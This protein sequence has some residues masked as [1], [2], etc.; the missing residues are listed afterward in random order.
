MSDQYDEYDGYEEYEDY[1]DYDDYD[2]DF[3]PD[4]P[5]PMMS[6]QGQPQ[7][8][9]FGQPPFGPPQGQ[10]PFGPPQGQPPFGPPQGPPGQPFLMP[11]APGPHNFGQF[12]PNMRPPNFIPRRPGFLPGPIRQCRNRF[13][14]IWLNNGRSFW[15][16]ISSVTPRV[17]YGYRWNVRRWIYFEVFVFNIIT[18]VCIR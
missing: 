16:W 18:F 14:Y 5:G 3:R 1:E 13:A 6:P 7:G 10:P 2:D 15:A 17:V 12:A 11:Y 9:P 8:Q 4:G